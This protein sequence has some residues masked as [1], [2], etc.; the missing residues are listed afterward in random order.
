[1]TI[2]SVSKTLSGSSL[3]TPLLTT[4][5]FQCGNLGLLVW[6]ML[7]EDYLEYLP[8]ELNN[9]CLAYYVKGFTVYFLDNYDN[10]R[11]ITFS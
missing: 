1:M 6:P 4:L 10:E 8:N 5:C 11:G 3:L 7:S 2:L 9:K